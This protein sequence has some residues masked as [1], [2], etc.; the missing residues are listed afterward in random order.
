M[1]EKLRL[2]SDD[3]RD[4][5]ELEGFVGALKGIESNPI[6][7]LGVIGVVAPI[8]ARVAARYAIG[9]ISERLKVRIS[10]KVRSEIALKAGERTRAFVRHKRRGK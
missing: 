8:V 7:W 3:A 10:P 2:T 5:G 6:D 9:K 1:K 4:A